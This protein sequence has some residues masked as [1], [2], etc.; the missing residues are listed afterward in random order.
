MQ[1]RMEFSDL[2]TEPI[3]TY[4]ARLL[5]DDKL[6][7]TPFGPGLTFAFIKGG[8]CVIFDKLM[9]R[10]ARIPTDRFLDDSKSG[11]IALEL[12]LS[13]KQAAFFL[14]LEN[15]VKEEVRK[16]T[17]LKKAEIAQMKPMVKAPDS[18]FPA[19]KLVLKAKTKA[20]AT[21]F[22]K[23][24]EDPT[25]G[26]TET[27][28]DKLEKGCL[29]TV[30]FA[31][32]LVWKSGMGLGIKW[33]VAQA[34]VIHEPKIPTPVDEVY[35][36]KTPFGTLR[37]RR[38]IPSPREIASAPF[39]R[40]NLAKWG[41]GWPPPRHWRQRLEAR[42]MVLSP[43]PLPK[44]TQIDSADATDDPEFLAKMAVVAASHTPKELLG[45]A[46]KGAYSKPSEEE[47]DDVPPPPKKEAKKK[48]G[49]KKPRATKKLDSSTLG[50]G[51]MEVPKSS[52]GENLADGYDV[53][54]VHDS[55]G[56][57]EG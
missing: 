32:K 14:K 19:H 23:A 29:M 45:K 43:P 55:D 35:Y 31:P 54:S 15:A 9:V 56:P 12:T 26:K 48:D 40:A 2:S 38:S 27:S 4:A 34:T 10:L 36:T 13:P 22:F 7:E 41:V 46:V 25:E 42:W 21:R 6:S 53:L 17:T 33:T 51:V 16:Q 44:L 30:S 20:N 11:D 47:D 28:W 3:A 50:E 49:P 8:D 39:T 37:T 24:S 5:V 18:A 57:S 52:V 1:D